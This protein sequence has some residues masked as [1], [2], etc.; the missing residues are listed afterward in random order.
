MAGVDQTGNYRK[1]DDRY[2]TNCQQVVSPK[3]RLSY[4]GLFGT[5]IVSMMFFTFVS[6]SLLLGFI[7]GGCV[8]TWDTMAIPAR[9]MSPPARSVMPRTSSTPKPKIALPDAGNSTATRSGTGRSDATAT[10]GRVARRGVRLA[11]RSSPLGRA[12]M[13]TTFASR[14]SQKRARWDLNRRK[15]VGL[16]PLDRCDFQ[17]SNPLRAG[18]V[19]ASLLPARARWDLN[20]RPSDIFRRHQAVPSIEVRRSSPD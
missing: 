20:P 15:T 9:W 19:V 1:T 12:E 14:A 8:D 5:V 18:S 7:L 6:A 2:C 17:G 11:A 3:R 13:L 4:F 10:R 16:A